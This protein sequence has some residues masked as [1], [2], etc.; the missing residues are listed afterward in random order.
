MIKQ[1]TMSQNVENKYSKSLRF[2]SYNVEN[3]FDTIN[4]P[5]Y[6]DNDFTPKGRFKWNTQRYKNKLRHISKVISRV[7]QWHWPAIVGL[8]EIENSNTLDD[9][10]KKTE[11][12]KGEYR[13]VL[14]HGEDTRGINVALLYRPKFIEIIEK[15]E[16]P[17]HFKEDE[18]KKSRN[19]LH[20][21]VLLLKSVILDIFVCHLPSK[22]EGSA[23]SEIFRCEVAD[24]VRK[25]CEE[26]YKENSEAN[27][28]IMGDFNENPDDRAL[29]QSLKTVSK[30]INI[31]ENNG[32]L[33]LVN[34]F[35]DYKHKN[36]GSYYYKGHWDQLDQMI[37]SS[38][39]FKETSK[40]RYKHK[41][42][43]VYIDDSIVSKNNDNGFKIP[44]RTFKGDFYTGGYSDHLP[45]Y[46]D[47]IIVGSHIPLVR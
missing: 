33:Q 2:M 39:F 5:N 26:L 38:T 25:K 27:I 35:E 1:Y 19:I 24:I 20:A 13:Y 46:A 22:R 12:K 43:R 30:N 21:K 11:L 34:I 14:T 10:I 41:S 6:N 31:L 7:G 28:L 47:F 42:A 16:Y 44:L 4:S 45:I 29:K 15:N 23:T 17:I 37:L 40:I 8:V 9:L 18:N 32:G 3:L 36:I